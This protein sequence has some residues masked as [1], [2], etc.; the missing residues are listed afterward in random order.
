MKTETIKISVWVKLGIMLVRRDSLPSNHPES[1]Y[2]VI[3]KMDL[4]PE[5]YGLEYKPM[6]IYTL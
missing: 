4:I 6:C 5:E 1:N 3:K 2:Q